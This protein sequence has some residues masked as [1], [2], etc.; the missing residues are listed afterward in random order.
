MD[1]QVLDDLKTQVRYLYRLTR[2]V[3]FESHALA[4]AQLANIPPQIINFASDYIELRETGQPFSTREFHDSE[5][6]KE[7]LNEE[8]EIEETGNAVFALKEFFKFMS[9]NYVPKKNFI[10]LKFF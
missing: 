3:T 2:G 1:L 8:R 10:Y 7:L 9:E 6:R 4:C 5:Y